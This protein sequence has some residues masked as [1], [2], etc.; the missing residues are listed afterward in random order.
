MP[1]NQIFG[2]DGVNT[3]T[4]GAGEDLI[5]GFNPNGTQAD[6]SGITATRVGNGFSQPV[7]A[8]AIPGDFGHLLVVEKGGLVRV[9]DLAT[10]AI[11]AT[12]F[13][14]VTQDVSTASERGLLG[15]AFDPDY[16]QNGYVYVS[17]TNDTNGASEVRRY[18]VVNGV[19]DPGTMQLVI[20][21]PQDNFDNHKGGWIGFGPDGYLYIALG[22]GGGGGDPNNNAQNP[23]LLLGKMLR[24]DVDGDAFP[25]DANN[26][27]TIPADNPFVG[28]TGADEIYALGLRNPWRNSFDLATGQLFI[29][30]VGQSNA[31]E[32]NI[33]AAG[34]NYGW[35]RY[36]G[37]LDYNTGTALTIGTL[38]FPIHTYDQNPSAS[39]TG[40]YVYRGE[41]DG[42]QG[43]Y[44]FADFVSGRVYT[45][46]WNGAA[47]VVT[48]RT[49][50]INE[51]VG[52]L[53]SPA[54][55]AQDAA[56]N[57]YAI[58]IG[59]AIYRLTPVTT[60]ADLGDTLSGLGGNDTLYGGAGADTLD[61][62]ADNDRLVGGDGND[63][64]IGGSGAD[65]L[66]G[67]AGVDTASY[68]DSAAGVIVDLGS[69]AS[70]DGVSNDVFTSIENATGSAFN[71]TIYGTGGANLLIGGAGADALFG[72]DGVDTVSYA[73]SNAGVTVNLLAGTGGGG[74][75]QGDTL[76][77]IENVIGSA[78]DDVF[79]SNA[80]A[81]TF[82]GGA[83][84]DTISYAGTAQGVIVDLVN[85]LTWDG[86]V[87]DVVSGIENM[88]GGAGNDQLWGN[89]GNNVFSG[90]ADGTDIF[91]GGGGF[92]TASYAAS[93]TAVIIDLGSAA[94]WDGSDNDF[95][96]QIHG[97]IGSALGDDIRGTG[98]VDQIDGGAGA[99]LLRGNDDA[100]VFVFRAG[101][102]NGD[103][104]ADFAG[105]SAATGDSFV[106]VGYGTA[107]QGAT[108]VQI[109]ATQWLITS[110]NGLITETITLANSASVHASDYTFVDSYVIGGG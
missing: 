5:Y 18:T 101:Q 32:I 63:T 80:A 49:G 46:R 66:I 102:A 60:S 26:N 98:G 29:A 30:D 76:N 28:V 44:F 20:T 55:F 77:T 86:A 6:A 95:L 90:G 36:E 35:R 106:F 88:I 10:G 13:L 57:L 16:A 75:A 1:V 12:P 38:T 107:A 91:S 8:A 104:I 34:A 45:M 94:T 39:I 47:W 37:N 93:L 87:N 4:G 22:D 53:S 14:D 43:Q 73:A 15:M 85:G 65:T 48:E 54:S 24:I 97:A 56:G 82:T 2:D 9:L 103:T 40:G 79:V 96:S 78:F 84:R 23:S 51:N 110:A 41:S 11:S 17:L 81:N 108:F 74:H 92:D 21:I 25:G 105:Q 7:F 52:T 100:D 89:S 59:G 67:G 64:L 19:A 72:F 50:Q 58:S 99:D 3:L 27:Y 31:E 33:G 68:A 62:G 83:G 71:D 70:W 109:N 69:G 61:G 42:L